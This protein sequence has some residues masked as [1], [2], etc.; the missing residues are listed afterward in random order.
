[1]FPSYLQTR[2]VLGYSCKVDIDDGKRV[3]YLIVGGLIMSEVILTREIGKTNVKN[4]SQ[5][6]DGYSLPAQERVMTTPS[7]SQVLLSDSQN[8]VI[9]V[10][11]PDPSK[12][13]TKPSVPGGVQGFTPPLPPKR[14]NSTTT[15]TS[16][17]LWRSPHKTVDYSPNRGA[18]VPRKGSEGKNSEND[19]SSKNQ[20]GN[21]MRS[22]DS[23]KGKPDKPDS[24]DNSN[25]VP[26][27]TSVEIESKADDTCS[28]PDHSEVYEKKQRNQKLNRKVQVGEEEFNLERSKIE[29]KTPTHG[30]DFGL[31]PMRDKD[32]EIVRHKK[33]GKPMVK[34]NK[35]NYEQFSDN[36]E[37]FI[38]DPNSKRVEATFRKGRENQQDVIGFIQEKKF[39]IFDKE[40]K[41]Y[42]TG[43]EMNQDQFEEYKANNNFV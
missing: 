28:T 30:S 42:I 1:M 36:I 11:N 8:L 6:C 5:T 29:K 39:I 34:Q 38:K 26:K 41:N 22:G 43:W 40:T 18:Q 25:Q 3:N 20:A 15:Q 27:Q 17:P 24:N 21:R 16:L 32:G 7:E 19:S 33:T 2:Q 14:G 4:Y 31:E 12:N 37:K 35:K 23:K 9:N 10:K 13:I